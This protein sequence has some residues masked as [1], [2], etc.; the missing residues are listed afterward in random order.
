VP[1]RRDFRARPARAGRVCRAERDD[2]TVV[3]PTPLMGWRLTPGGGSAASPG[4]GTRG[5]GLPQAACAPAPMDFTLFTPTPVHRRIL[6]QQGRCA[7]TVGGSRAESP[8]RARRPP[9]HRPHRSPPNAPA[10]RGSPR[11]RVAAESPSSGCRGFLCMGEPGKKMLQ[12][13]HA[14]TARSMP[15]HQSTLLHHVAAPQHTAGV[16]TPGG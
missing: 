11:F 5:K 13:R 15:H 1:R 7:G 10:R 3:L 14:V 4:R 6:A 16:L 12:I 8:P 9:K 2:H